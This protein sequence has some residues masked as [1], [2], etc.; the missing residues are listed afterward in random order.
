[1]NRYAAPAYVLDWDCPLLLACS[2]IFRA[3]SVYYNVLVIN[4]K[5]LDVVKDKRDPFVIATLSD[6]SR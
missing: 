4:K 2:D 1:V 6:V 3:G 5:S